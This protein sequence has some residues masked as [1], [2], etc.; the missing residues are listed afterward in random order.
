M[1]SVFKNYHSVLFESHKPLM[2]V[3]SCPKYTVKDYFWGNLAAVC[4][5]CVMP[6]LAGCGVFLTVGLD[7]SWIGELT[8][9]MKITVI[10]AW[11]LGVFAPLLFL[12]LA[13]PI[14]TY[15]DVKRDNRYSKQLRSNYGF[16][17]IV[18]IVFVAMAI[19]VT[20]A[21]SANVFGSLTVTVLGLGIPPASL[22]STSVG[23][24]ATWIIVIIMIVLTVCII[25]GILI[26]IHTA[27]AVQ[28]E[29]A[30]SQVG[31]ADV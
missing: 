4:L 24:I 8:D 18:M 6:I 30:K 5:L 19:G 20:F 26:A 13:L 22:V 3:L 29:P 15:I 7:F 2:T 23:I 28:C 17:I 16:M 27:N 12:L 21:A 11:I 14:L 25:S 31:S 10:M 1:D 9:G